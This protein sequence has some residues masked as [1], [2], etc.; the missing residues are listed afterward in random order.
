MR[1]NNSHRRYC[2]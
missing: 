1:L 2:R